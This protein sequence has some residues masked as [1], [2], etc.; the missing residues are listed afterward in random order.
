MGV[1]NIHL[2]TRL[3]RQSFVNTVIKSDLSVCGVVESWLKGSSGIM[4]AELFGTDWVWF[5]KERQGR[6]E[7]GLNGS[8]ARRLGPSNLREIQ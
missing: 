1:Q 8:N 7:Q 6:T 2:A 5:G 3:V 4:D